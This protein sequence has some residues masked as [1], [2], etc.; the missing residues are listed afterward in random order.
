MKKYKSFSICQNRS[1][2][3]NNITEYSRHRQDKEIIITKS[4]LR[5]MPGFDGIN[6]DDVLQEM[7][8]FLRF[9]Y[10]L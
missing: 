9:V 10:I 2:S 1:R 3:T 5:N 8:T 7:T 6:Q 4:F